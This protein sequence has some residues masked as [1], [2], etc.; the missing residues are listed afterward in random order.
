MTDQFWKLSSTKRRFIGDSSDDEQ[1]FIEMNNS[2]GE[3]VSDT[4]SDTKSNDEDI[5]DKFIVKM[6][7]KKILL[8]A[9]IDKINYTLQMYNEYI[10]E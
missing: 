8:Q 10:H 5:E 4:N 6:N 9:E 3:T 1:S 7:K 2:I